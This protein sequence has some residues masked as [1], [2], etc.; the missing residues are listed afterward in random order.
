M[1]GLHSE[2]ELLVTVLLPALICKPISDT[3]T[4]VSNVQGGQTGRMLCRTMCTAVAQQHM[5]VTLT[6]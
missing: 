5:H 2:I 1:K 6:Q 4:S 3:D